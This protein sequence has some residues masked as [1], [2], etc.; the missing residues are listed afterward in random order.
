MNSQKT[1]R[2]S[3]ESWCDVTLIVASLMRIS[4]ESWCNVTLIVASLMRISVESW[5]NVTL[6]VASL[7]YLDPYRSCIS[8]DSRLRW[9]DRWWEEEDSERQKSAVVSYRRISMSSF[10]DSCGGRSCL[11]W[12][13]I[14]ARR[15]SD[16]RWTDRRC[17]HHCWCLCFDS[18]TTEFMFSG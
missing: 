18:D 15:H 16:V 13:E 8:R 1:Q 6:I 4:V 7:M 3:V 12:N 11:S 17:F 14:F 9:Q 10:H 5:C 2:I